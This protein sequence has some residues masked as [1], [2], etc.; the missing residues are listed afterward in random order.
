[1]K[2]KKKISEI[3]EEK[4][5]PEMGSVATPMHTKIILEPIHFQTISSGHQTSGSIFHCL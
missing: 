3:F 1:M 5:K 2:Q 4:S